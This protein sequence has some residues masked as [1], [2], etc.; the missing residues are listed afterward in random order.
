[1]ERKIMFI[2][3]DTIRVVIKLCRDAIYVEKGFRDAFMCS[4]SIKHR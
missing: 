2:R 1:M 3:L 4:V